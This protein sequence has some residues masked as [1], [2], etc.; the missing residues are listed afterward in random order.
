MPNELS[1]PGNTLGS[2][3]IVNEGT[4]AL[5]ALL[6]WVS[7]QPDETDIATVSMGEN[8]PITAVVADAVE[9]YEIIWAPA[10]WVRSGRAV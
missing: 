4:I 6:A 10:G 3:E 8:M 2:S 9:T 1:K 7:D 5:E